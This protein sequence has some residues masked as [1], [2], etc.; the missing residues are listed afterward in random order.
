MGK[1]TA[2]N[3]TDFI[4]PLNMNGM[5]G[6]MMHLPHPS[7]T[8]NKEILFVYGHHSSLERWWGLV[9][10]LNRYAAVTVPDLPGFGGMDSFYKI[11]K[12]PSIDNLADYLAAFIKLRF[13]NKR[14]NVC[15]LSFGFVVITRMLQLYP[16]LAKRINI[17]VSVVGF[18]HYDDFSFSRRRYL[19]YV[20]G[21]RFFSHR[22]PAWA[23]RHIILQPSIL[24]K[25]Y[26][27]TYNAADKFHALEAEEFSA[28]M[29]MEISLWQLND[30]RTHFA[31]SVAMLTIDNCNKKVELPIWHVSMRADRYFNKHIVEQHLQVIFQDVTHIESALDAHAPSVIADEKMAA[32][33]IPPKLRRVLMKL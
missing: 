31:T 16:E 7:K 17:L 26:A 14:I 13:K 33:L 1:Q 6:R 12:E 32:P 23:Y 4:M 21:A 27:K 29:D 19:F 5:E 10:V 9:K 2:N 28:A 18:S 30:V 25:M 20:Y 11:G 8:R 22:M 3:P 24:R 15:G